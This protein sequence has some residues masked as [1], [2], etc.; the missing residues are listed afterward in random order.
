MQIKISVFSQLRKKS[1]CFFCENFGNNR[2]LFL[3]F[4][5]FTKKIITLLRMIQNKELCPLK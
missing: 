3:Y 1:G 4:T 5:L 2:F